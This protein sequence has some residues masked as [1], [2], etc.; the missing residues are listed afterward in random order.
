MAR[1]AISARAE[2]ARER[3]VYRNAPAHRRCLV[4]ADGL[5]ERK[6]DNGRRAGSRF[7]V[8]PDA[9]N[10]RGPNGP[11]RAPTSLS[12]QEIRPCATT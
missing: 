7:N 10:V 5:I 1:K 12:P 8:A 2:T 3:P 6:R 9:H 4:A 11:G